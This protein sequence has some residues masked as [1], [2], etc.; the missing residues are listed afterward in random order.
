[1]QVALLGALRREL[2]QRHGGTGEHTD[3]GQGNDQFDERET[4]CAHFS[5]HLM[6]MFS[7][8]DPAFASA[9]PDAPIADTC[10]V[11][12][13]AA[14]A[15]SALKRSSIRLPSPWTGSSVDTM[16]N[17][18]P[19][20]FASTVGLPALDGT[21][22]PAVALINCSSVESNRTCPRN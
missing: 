3:D 13:L 20:L 18:A 6:A 12:E 15:V 4:P 7:G 22:S 10:A 8:C 21:K 14:R 2:H 17:W 1:M 11:M 19:P 9:A 16:S 5:P